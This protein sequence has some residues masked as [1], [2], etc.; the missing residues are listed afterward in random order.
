MITFQPGPSVVGSPSVSAPPGA[1]VAVAEGV[2]WMP[3]GAA[4]GS[5]TWSVRT[6]PAPSPSGASRDTV[7]SEPPPRSTA[8]ESVPPQASALEFD[9]DG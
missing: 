7:S 5:N 3:A 1:A 4:C 2:T 6:D 8:S 9:S